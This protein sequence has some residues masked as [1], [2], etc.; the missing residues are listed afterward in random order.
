MIRR[1]LFGTLL[2]AMLLAACQPLETVVS[3]PRVATATAQ[4]NAVAP[5]ETP[6]LLP[7]P[8][9][10]PRAGS[11]SGEEDVPISAP[12]APPLTLWVNDTAPE[13]ATLIRE[14]AQRFTAQSG[15]PIETIF[16]K[17]DAV[18]TLLRTAAATDTMPDLVLHSFEQTGGWQQDGLLNTAAT[19]AVVDQLGRETFAPGALDVLRAENGEIAAV[20]L[21]TWQHFLVYRADWFGRNNLPAPDSF[22]DIYNAAETF[23]DPEGV[24]SGLVVATDSKLS[25]TQRIFEHMAIANGCR[26][27]DDAGEITAIHPACLETLDFYRDVIN[28]FSPVGFQTDISALKAY[29]G[30]RTGLILVDANVLP[31]LA[32][33]DEQSLPNCAECATNPRYLVE[34]SGFVTALQGNGTYS[35]AAATYPGVTALGIT[36]AANAEAAQAFATF[37]LSDGYVDWLSLFPEWKAPLRLHSAEAQNAYLDA[38]RAAPLRPGGESLE[39]LFGPDLIAQ[40]TSGLAPI[41]RWGFKEGQPAVISRV[42]PSLELSQMLQEML[43][44]YITSSQA[45]FELYNRSVAQIPNYGF[46][47]STP[48]PLEGAGDEASDSAETDS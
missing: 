17:S 45:V 30:G 46:D 12:T 28:Q 14:L 27:V 47:V 40:M 22:A 6:L 34:N 13:T 26:L 35:S 48:A 21:S 39:T 10:T 3:P 24:T 44:G 42:Y 41:E 31:A 9:P 18:S 16:V 19:T 20:P 1:V 8:T 15:I 25:S 38:W 4:A 33:Y 7:A 2:L 37:L 32:G 36:S 23:Y 43:S 5:Q 11:V 29:L